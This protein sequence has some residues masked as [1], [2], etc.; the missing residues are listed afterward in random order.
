MNKLLLTLLLFTITFVT[1]A[2]TLFQENFESGFPGQLTLGQL[3]GTTQWGSGCSGINLGGATC[4]ISGSTSATFFVNAYTQTV[5]TLNLPPLNLIANPYLLKFKHIQRSWDGDVNPLY[6]RISN[7]NGT[8]FQTMEIFDEATDNAT[9]RII[10]LSQFTVS[11]SSIIQFAVVNSW[12]YATIL[13]DIQVVLNTNQNDLRL[14]SFDMETYIVAGSKPIQGTIIN[15]GGN[16]V[17]SLS[18]KYQ[19]GNGTIFNQNISNLNLLPGQTY[20]YSHQDIWNAPGDSSNN[21]KVWV[22][23]VN[24][25]TDFSPT[26]NEITK[27]I[28]VSNGSSIYK[29]MFEKFTGS[30]CAPCA[31]YNN[32]TFNPFYTAQN[33]NFNYVAY[34]MNWPGAG[35]PYYTLEGNTRKGYYG[36]NSITS[37]WINGANYSTSNNQA[38]LTTHLNNE[39]AKPGFFGLLAGREIANNT[40]TVNYVITPYYSGNFTLH[41]AV[42]E[43]IT[44]GNIGT[45]GETSFKHVMMKMVPNANG[46]A[47]TTVAGTTI[48]GQIS[49]SLAGTFIE[50]MSDLEVIVFLQ[51]NNNKRVL[52]S[53]KAQ[54]GLLKNDKFEKETVKV[55]PNPANEFIQLSNIENANISITDISGKVVLNQNNVNEDVSINISNLTAGV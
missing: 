22:D 4:P 5:S 49:A 16:T 14:S 23:V 40:A 54:V 46:T 45:N 32:S 10:N 53:A 34:Q 15:L 11:A 6:I 26:D 27:L 42:I 17:N 2:Q 20:N 8:T 1:N 29:P 41:A 47:I 38:T 13:D 28:F 50:E 35:D 51:D 30:T 25:V 3:A 9:E 21:I 43:N 55:Y 37:L 52:Q 12:G 19:I 48:S 33:Q 7:N 24:G 39:A 36:I 44:T 18:L 31:S